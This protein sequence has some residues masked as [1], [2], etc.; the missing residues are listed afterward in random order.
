[1]RN[2]KIANA[3]ELLTAANRLGI[4]VS[5]SDGELRVSLPGEEQESAH[6]LPR[7]K[8]G[9]EDLLYYFQGHKVAGM[10]TAS[11]PVI[12]K[13]ASGDRSKV[14]LS[15]GQRRLWFIHQLQG[16]IH[17]HTPLALRL[18]GPLNVEALSDTIKDIIRRHEVLR[19]VI[20]EEDGVSYQRIKEMVDFELRLEAAGDILPVNEEYYLTKYIDRL[21]DE[22]F[23]LVNDLM[24][25]VGLLRL[26]EEE[27]VL[28]INLH[29]IVSDGM[30]IPVFVRELIELYTARSQ[31]RPERLQPLAVQ[32]A[33]YAVWQQQ[34]FESNLFEDKVR[35]WL[36]RLAGASGFA[37]A[38]DRQG[39]SAE[40]IDGAT[41]HYFID[42]ELAAG[43]QAL[44]IQHGCTPFI[45]LLSAFYLL[46]YRYTGQDDICVGTPVAGRDQP[47]TIPLI[48]FFINMLVLRNKVKK[49]ISFTE[50][51][52]DV[53][54]NVLSD[55]DRQDVPFEKV[56]E[57]MRE[58][59]HNASSPLF[60]VML[61]FQKSD[62]IMED[63]GFVPAISIA[64][65]PI[66]NKTSKFNISIAFIETA[67]G[68]GMNLE[69][70]TDLYSEQ[71]M[72][73]LAGHYIRLLGAILKQPDGIIDAFQFL[74]SEEEQYL[75]AL[76]RSVST[77]ASVEP[78]WLPLPQRLY[79]SIAAH[80]ENVAIHYKERV[81][82]YECF[83]TLVE[84]YF[85]RIR[86]LAGSPG[87]R[88]IAILLEKSDQMIAAAAAVFLAG[89]VY[90]P[91]DTELPIERIQFIIGDVRPVLVISTRRH[92]NILD[93]LSTPVFFGEEVAEG[94][95]LFAAAVRPAEVAAKDEAYIIYTSGSSGLPKGVI[96]SHGNLENFFSHICKEYAASP[97][98]LPFVASPSFDISLF[99]MFTP[100]IS[101]GTCIVAGRDD[102][103]DPDR[104]IGLLQ[105]ATMLDT[106]P[107]LYETLVDYIEKQRLETHVDHLQRI[108]IGGDHISDKLLQSLPKI[109]RNAAITVTYG[110]TEGTIFCA[111]MTYDPPVLAGSGSGAWIGSPISGAEIYIMSDCQQLMPPGV[112]GEIC[113][114]GRVVTKGYLNGDELTPTKYV[115]NPYPGNAILYR[116]G[117]M[118][119][120]IENGR[121]EFKGRKDHQVKIRGYRIETSEIENVLLEGGYA[122]QCTVIL[123]QAA[124]GDKRLAAFFVATRNFQKDEV[125][126][127]L[128]AKLPPY[129]IPSSI[130]R[131]MEMPLTQNG[132]VD[133][134]ALANMETEDFRQRRYEPPANETEEALVAI[135][136]ELL[137]R[138]IGVDDG[139]FEAGGNSLLAIRM[140]AEV[141]NRIG[142]KVHVKLFL[143]LGNIRAISDYIRVLH[144]NKAD[145][146]QQYQKIEL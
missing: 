107:A 73:K 129:M 50:F 46:M 1:M 132:K 80:R 60:N 31:G 82:S 18:K 106:V 96:V 53:K 59:G 33:D 95:E 130:T 100:L 111:D 9:K 66:R 48:G 90:V 86:E 79:Y 63:P 69:Y 124:N 74:H 104:F 29:H 21:I 135:W 49:G 76:G 89:A 23:D 42:Q 54:E 138:E 67:A 139:F 52:H 58:E 125:W 98:S 25:R 91:I 122:R 146:C 12:V 56:V 57:R 55:Y 85:S 51:L 37:I 65:Q 71:M 8:A 113:I 112:T 87:G 137:G 30:S 75:L 144:N 41:I 39:A 142:Y 6:F 88:R 126:R 81:I 40:S 19:T 119:C 47:E 17:Y 143:Q 2:S 117:D 110:P 83:G 32:Y 84:N 5:F 131:I 120:W 77:M 118:G 36:W 70:A 92:S 121:L 72:Q 35:Y 97:V 133:R 34:C 28:V 141:K 20:V 13:R 78:A 101:G 99:Q 103:Q 114:G 14:P 93:E 10:S 26:R 128:N 24:I 7:L 105:G 44:S 116:T 94:D 140:A 43:I 134:K 109:F 11:Y 15:F 22:P 68:I 102:I 115:N 38:G 145:D 127:Y 27:Y 16:S 45:T 62:P 136:R 61:A 64:E 4:K 108:F 123:Q 3:M